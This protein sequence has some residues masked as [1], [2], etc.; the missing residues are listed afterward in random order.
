MQPNQ[1]SFYAECVPYAFRGSAIGQSISYFILA[2]FTLAY[3]LITGSHKKTWD[4][5][6]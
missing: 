5:K 4:G 2:A 3:M 6:A 1:M